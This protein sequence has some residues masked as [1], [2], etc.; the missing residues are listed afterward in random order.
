[1]AK[2]RRIDTRDR[3][4][5]KAGNRGPDALSARSY[6]PHCALERGYSTQKAVGKVV[7]S[8]VPKAGPIRQ[9]QGRLRGTPFLFISLHGDQGHPPG[10]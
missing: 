3:A 2:K 9:A 1:M 6:Y 10:E 5:K 7:I 8:Q 4:D